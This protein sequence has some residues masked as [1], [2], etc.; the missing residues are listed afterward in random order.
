MSATVRMSRW[1]ADDLVPLAERLRYMEAC[2]LAIAAVVVA[3]AVAPHRLLGVSGTSWLLVATGGF[4]SFFAAGG[5][6][7]RWSGRRG[8]PVFGAL[9]VGDALFLG[10]VTWATGGTASPLRFL[11]AVH[12]VAVTLL[13]SYRTSLRLGLWH[14]LIL[15]SIYY[16]EQAGHRWPGV[17]VV[18]STD[19]QLQFAAFLVALWLL[20]LATA[21]FSAVNERELRRR[22]YDLEA[23]AAMAARIEQASGPEQVAGVLVEAVAEEFGFPRAMVLALPS[24][25]P[26]V[27]LAGAGGPKAGLKL[28]VQADSV[29]GELYHRR[30]TMLLSDLPP[31]DHR[32]LM[33]AMPGAG[34][35]ALF[36]MTSE[37]RCIGVLVAEHSLARGSR[38]ER[39]VVSAV[40]RFASHA[41]LALRNALLLEEARRSAVTD[42]LTGIANRRGFQDRLEK[43][44]SRAMRV[45]EELSLVLLDLDHFKALNDTYGH[46]MGDEVLKAVAAALRSR[47]RHFDTPARYGG[48]EF[49]V[50][51]PSCGLAEAV[52]VAESLREAIAAIDGLPAVTV[53]AGAATL[54]NH[55]LD[56]NSLLGSADRALYRSKRGG[57][58]RVSAADVAL[59]DLPVPAWADDLATNAEVGLEWPG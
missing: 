8:L 45:G 2:R 36:A 33:E 42:A 23:L 20:A 1:R 15:T 31:A 37:G 50:V 47:L 10:F 25:G 48:E 34:D 44:V 39:R 12:L 16:A 29:L 24:E 13:A 3:V 55:G 7:W 11:M 54:P 53:S 5:A 9:L 57:R 41:A 6:L 27:V 28:A 30:S 51:L 18:T 56:W 52:T 40:E 35:V 26:P 58:N 19:R 32:W 38:I 17:P 49:A 22:R 46:Q 21:A 59:G 43:E 14:S 4:V